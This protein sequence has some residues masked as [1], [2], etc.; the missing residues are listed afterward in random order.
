MRVQVKVLLLVGAEAEVI[1][2]ATDAAT[3]V[4]YPAAEIAA[5]VGLSERELP[6]KK[7]TAEV[8]SRERLSGW[9]LA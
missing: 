5:A 8:D 7:L 6:G 1:A 9:A 3:P 2:D 4:R